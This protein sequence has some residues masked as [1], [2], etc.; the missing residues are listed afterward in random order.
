MTP[1]HWV[2]VAATRP[3][4]LGTAARPRGGAWLD[5]ELRGWRAAGVERVVSMLTE[6]EVAELELGDAA[7]AAARAGLRL[8]RVPVVDRGLPGSSRVVAAAA[9]EAAAV[10]RGGGGVV[11]HCR[12]GIGRASMMAAAVLIELGV[13]WSAALG[14]IEAARGRSIPDTREQ[15]AWVE[16]YAA[17]RRLRG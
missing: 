6:P 2:E 13:E 14:A 15:R 8:V 4:R 12:Q 10:L 3:G 16:Q 5:D 7:A 1:I 9:G 17:G 11:T